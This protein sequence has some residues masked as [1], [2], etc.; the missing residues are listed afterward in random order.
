MLGNCISQQHVARSSR[1]RCDARLNPVSG[2]RRDVR[3]THSGVVTAHKSA[4]EII[5]PI[6]INHAVRISV[7]E[8][9]TLGCYS[10][11]VSSVTQ[12]MIALMNIAHPWELRCDI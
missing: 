2:W 4:D 8:H 3:S 11:G 10:A 9:L 6:R 5:Q 1:C 12:S 7:G